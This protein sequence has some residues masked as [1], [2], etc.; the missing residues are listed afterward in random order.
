M[1]QRKMSNQ[2]EFISQALQQISGRWFTQIHTQNKKQG[3]KQDY[4]YHT[5]NQ[6]FLAIHKVKNQL[7]MN[8][9]KKASKI[10]IYRETLKKI[11]EYDKIHGKDAWY[12][13]KMYEKD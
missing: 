1:K 3:I 10:R 5:M 6:L 13:D 12:K 7:D 2:L 4:Y 9:D 11:E 8:L